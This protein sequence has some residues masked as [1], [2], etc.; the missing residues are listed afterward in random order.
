MSLIAYTDDLVLIGKMEKKIRTLAELLIKRN[1]P[2]ELM[3]NK[4]NTIKENIRYCRT[5]TIFN[6]A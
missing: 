5:R 2:I 4:E 3:V 6:K 1:R